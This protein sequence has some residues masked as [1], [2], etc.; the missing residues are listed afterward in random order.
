V[1]KLGRAVKAQA[2]PFD[3]PPGVRG[4][5]YLFSVPPGLALAASRGW[6]Q[7][8]T[9]GTAERRCERPRESRRRDSNPRHPLYKSGALAN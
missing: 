5:F 2:T 6:T 7:T 9:R 4:D 1:L 8:V 3:G